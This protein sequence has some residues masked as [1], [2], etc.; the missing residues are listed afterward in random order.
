MSVRV[1]RERN[2][3]KK[4]LFLKVFIRCDRSL[5][6]DVMAAAVAHNSIGTAGLSHYTLSS[7]WDKGRKEEP[8][9]EGQSRNAASPL[10]RWNKGEHLTE[11]ND[12][13]R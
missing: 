2:I 1:I 11:A 8:F 10:A 7:R 5:I 13:R 12:G 6:I 9:R 3:L 4:T